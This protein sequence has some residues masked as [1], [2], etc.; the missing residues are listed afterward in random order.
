MAQRRFH[1]DLAFEHY[2]REHGIPYVNVDEARRAPGI[3]PQD[4]THGRPLKSFDFVVYSRTGPNL[5]VDVKGRKHA[6][7]TRRA[8]QNW[9]TRADVDSLTRWQAIFGD[10]FE[11]AFAFLYWCDDPPPDPLFR[12]TIEVN[13]RWYCLLA[14]RLA[15]YTP[16]ARTRSAS[17]DT[18][19]I[20]A[21]QFARRA[22]PLPNLL[23]PPAPGK[24]SVVAQRR[25]NISAASS[26]R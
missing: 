1:Y 11:A 14:I 12:E 21:A 3:A 25:N 23:N 24:G 6:G 8:L 26:A 13:G 19:S 2:L 17:W 4:R 16:H 20:P 7:R 5:L 15:D 22:Q 10:G 9:V 18:V